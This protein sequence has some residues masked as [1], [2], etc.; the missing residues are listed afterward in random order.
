MTAKER[1]EQKLLELASHLEASDFDDA[2]SSCPA[3][4]LEN[5]MN[6]NKEEK[7][8]SSSDEGEDDTEDSEE[9]EEE[10]A[11]SKDDEDGEDDEDEQSSGDEN[12][13][14]EEGSDE[15]GDDE[16]EENDD[17]DG[18]EEKEEKDE[19]DEAVG[20]KEDKN[21]EKEPEKEMHA[22]VPVVDATQKQV[23]EVKNSV[24]HKREWDTFNRQAK[25]RMPVNLNGMFTTGKQE[26]FNLW[27]DLNM[28]WTAC[29]LHVERK[30]E[31]K[32][33]STK[34]WVA[35]QGKELRATYPADKY[36]VL[37]AK[38]KESG[39][40]YEDPD[41]PGDEDEPWMVYVHYLLSVTLQ[42]EFCH[43]LDGFC[44]HSCFT[45]GSANKR[46]GLALGI[47]GDL[48]MYP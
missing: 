42:N 19:E 5:M 48:K 26:L 33:V 11:E 13:E 41:F 1:A 32:H 24:T 28:D 12:D 10:D 6:L 7:D 17:E 45:W 22:L 15:A 18:Q 40:F 37:V 20:A 47:L 3:T 38:R 21:K 43:L 25:S 31:Q 2:E 14:E 16:E 29:S 39:M 36:K 27:M 46:L 34:G 8:I 44:H 9:E 35:K 23:A 4:D 30:Q